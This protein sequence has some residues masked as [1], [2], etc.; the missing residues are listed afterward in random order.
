MMNRFNTIERTVKLNYKQHATWIIGI[1]VVIHLLFYAIVPKGYTFDEIF[2]IYL[3][4]FKR[5]DSNALFWLWLHL[6]VE[7]CLFGFLNDSLNKSYSIKLVK[8][9]DKRVYVL[10]SFF[11]VLILSMTYYFIGYLMI[12]IMFFP[13]NIQLG[14]WLWLLS[15]IET[16]NVILISFLMGLIFKKLENIIFPIVI[17]IEILSCCVCGEKRADIFRLLPFTQSKKMLQCEF[18]D[19]GFAFIISFSH[20]NSSMDK[21]KRGGIKNGNY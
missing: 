13:S 7:G 11:C 10:S 2:E 9:G 17:I 21:E 12:E 3:S 4:G 14:T 16:T 15:V 6:P 8:Y 5:P 20:A 19:N 1:S 18:F